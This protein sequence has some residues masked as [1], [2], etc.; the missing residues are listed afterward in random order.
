MNISPSLLHNLDSPTY[1]YHFSIQYIYLFVW[2]LII[3]VNSAYMEPIVSDAI[4]TIILLFCFNVI[5]A[6]VNWRAPRK[7][8]LTPKTTTPSVVH[9]IPLM[10]FVV[11]PLFL[12][13]LRLDSTYVESQ[14]LLAKLILSHWCFV[15]LSNPYKL[16]TKR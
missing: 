10:V 16:W 9:S 1:N 14:V 7:S 3:T 11:N 4:S 6:K 8:G 12:G 5:F 13:G 15:H 2:E